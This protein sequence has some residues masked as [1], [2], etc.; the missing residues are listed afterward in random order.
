MIRHSSGLVCVSVENDLADRLNLPLMVSSKENEDAMKTAFTVS[1]DLKTST[2]GISAGGARG[3]HRA[4]R[5]PGRARGRLRASGSRLPLRY[6]EGGVLKRTGH[7]EAALDLA[8]MAG[9]GPA[10]GVLPGS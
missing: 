9:C 4:S 7:T 8:R 5:S 6:R 2:T 10:V 1:V 3:D